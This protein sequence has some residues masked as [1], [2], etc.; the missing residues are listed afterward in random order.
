MDSIKYITIKGTTY[1]LEGGEGGSS[2]ITAVKVGDTSY[3]PD[4]GGVISLPAYPEGGDAGYSVLTATEG[5][6][7]VSLVTTGEKF[8]WNSG[9]NA[10]NEALKSTDVEKVTNM[11][12]YGQASKPNGQ[13][14]ITNITSDNIG[15]YAVAGNVTVVNGTSS[16]EWN[17]DVTVGTINGTPITAKLP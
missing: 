17:T 6:R 10:A 14:D 5:G 15:D 12:L 13:Q 7:D 11:L 9:A 2:N 1:Q 16:L 3:T 8:T 4:G